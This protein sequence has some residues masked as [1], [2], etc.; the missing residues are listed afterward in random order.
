M[1]IQKVLGATCD[2]MNNR[3]ISTR[4]LSGQTDFLAHALVGKVGVTEKENY[5]KPLD[6]NITTVSNKVPFLYTNLRMTF[7][8]HMYM[9]NI[10]GRHLQ[11]RR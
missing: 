4:R 2:D 8:D 11:L 10:K 7:I 6:V 1:Y 3:Y 9:N 5:N